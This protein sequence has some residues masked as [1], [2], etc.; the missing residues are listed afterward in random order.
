MYGWP[1]ADWK[2]FI[3]LLTFKDIFSRRRI[4]GRQVFLS[5]CETHRLIVLWHALFLWQCCL[6]C[7]YPLFLQLPLKFLINFK[8]LDFEGPSFAGLFIL[9]PV[10]RIHEF[11]VFIKFRKYQAII[12]FKCLGL[13]QG[14]KLHVFGL[15]NMYHH[16]FVHELLSFSS[17][18]VVFAVFKLT[19]KINFNFK[20]TCFSCL[21][22]SSLAFVILTPRHLLT[23]E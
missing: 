16:S 19:F 9:F 13:F 22:F 8:Q 15:L 4:L 21:Y 20:I 7:F 6:S 14:L 12:F 5:V 17:Q 11:I 3:S 10:L 18:V 2:V 1:F 23:H